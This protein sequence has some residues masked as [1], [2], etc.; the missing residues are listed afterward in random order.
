MKTND[1]TT[2]QAPVS[3]YANRVNSVRGGRLNDKTVV[4][5]NHDVADKVIQAMPTQVQLLIMNIDEITEQ[6][7]KCS[8]ISLNNKWEAYG[9]KQDSFYVLSHYLTK[10]NSLGKVNSNGKKN[11]DTY[12]G[13]DKQ[14]LVSLFSITAS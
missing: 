7:D 8:M 3:R 11:P 4:A 12:K 14:T 6:L 10:F 2:K 9:Y 13:F 5:V 1:K